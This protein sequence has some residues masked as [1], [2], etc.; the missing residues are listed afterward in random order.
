MLLK[1]HLPKTKRIDLTPCNERAVSKEVTTYP[2][3][4]SSQPIHSAHSLIYHLITRFHTHFFTRFTPFPTYLRPL[5][6]LLT[7]PSPPPHPHSS[8]PPGA[9]L[10][11]KAS[12]KGEPSRKGSVKKGS[13]SKSGQG[14]MGNNEMMESQTASDEQTNINNNNRYAI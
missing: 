12:V 6:L 10:E 2:L 13:P 11:R 14:D 5:S 8:H 3:Y 7:H 1:Y 4:A 9:T